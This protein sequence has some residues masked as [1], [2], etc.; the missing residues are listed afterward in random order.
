VSA[1]GAHDRSAQGAIRAAEEAIGLEPFR[2]A[3]YRRLMRVHAALGN[4]AEALRVHGCC[5][6][7]LTDELGVDPSP[8]TEAVYL[9][10]LRS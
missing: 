8:Q 7:R 2:E 9:E 4:R 1:K 6:R 5:R 3:G 10:M